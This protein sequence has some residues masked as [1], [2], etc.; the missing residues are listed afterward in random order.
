MSDENKSRGGG[1]VAPKPEVKIRSREQVDSARK[2]EIIRAM[3]DAAEIKQP[4][5][6]A[7]VEE[8]AQLIGVD[9]R[10]R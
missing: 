3:R 2:A 4:V 1:A 5:E 8:L 10:R 9:I 6:L 7:W